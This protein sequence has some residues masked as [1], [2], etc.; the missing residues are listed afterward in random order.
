MEKLSRIIEE[1][2]NT[3]RDLEI[4]NGQL[5]DTIQ[6]KTTDELLQR[7]SEIT[8]LKKTINE[9]R[10][11]NSQLKNDLQR[12]IDEREKDIVDAESINFE[13][14]KEMLGSVLIECE[15]TERVRKQLY[16]DVVQN[17]RR[18]YMAINKIE[19]ATVRRQCETRIDEFRMEYKK[20]SQELSNVKM[21]LSA[22]TQ[23]S[24]EMEQ[25]Y[26]HAKQQMKEYENQEKIRKDEQWHL[27]NSA[28]DVQVHLKSVT[29]HNRKLFDSILSVD[30]LIDN[31]RSEWTFMYEKVKIRFQRELM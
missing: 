1:K 17:I 2:R 3:I 25:K 14:R 18:E 27:M 31:P 12:H 6:M 8:S 22:T 15:A 30:A 13:C 23:R 29:K 28:I 19:L 16:I 20:A 7:N 11:M 10:Q 26:L 9:L 21:Q 5:N 24:N 4:M